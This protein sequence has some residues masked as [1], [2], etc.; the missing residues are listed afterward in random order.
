M[1]E[2]FG[3]IE[4]EVV[5]DDLLIWE[6]QHD[7]RLENVLQRARKRNLKL[8][9]EGGQIP[10]SHHRRRWY[11]TRSKEGDCSHRLNHQKPRKN[12]NVFWA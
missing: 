3:D 12:Y 5:V 11:Q 6:E 9:K 2:M 8:N 1:S 4:D 10:W 7:S